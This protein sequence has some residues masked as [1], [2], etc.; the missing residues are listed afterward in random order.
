MARIDEGS[1]SNL[2]IHVLGTLRASTFYTQLVDKHP[3]IAIL[4]YMWDWKCYS[5]LDT[6]TTLFLEY[7]LP[8]DQ[9]QKI[10]SVA[11]L[12]TA[13]TALEKII[14]VLFGWRGLFAPV[15]EIMRPMEGVYDQVCC[16]DFWLHRI[17]NMLA[18]CSKS[19]CDARNYGA[20]VIP[21]Q[22]L[23]IIKDII[24]KTAELSYNHASNLQ[25]TAERQNRLKYAD[26]MVFGDIKPPKHEGERKSTTNPSITVTAGS[27]T[28][29]ANK[30]ATGTTD[31]K[32]ENR[33]AP[34]TRDFSAFATAGVTV[35]TYT[36][37]PKFL[38]C[39]VD[40]MAHY[41]IDFD[42]GSQAKACT[43]KHEAT[44]G[45]RSTARLHFK[46]ILTAYPQRYNLA[47]AKYQA[48]F[49]F[50]NKPSVAVRLMAALDA[51]KVNFK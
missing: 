24:Q 10:S 6:K 28:P 49:W 48:C 12:F 37:R 20:T 7:F 51:D 50:F 5:C 3:D 38:I 29:A 40:L 2:F 22:N 46:D 42:D 31:R 19:T 45:S 34:A 47:S 9:Y 36:E 41:K 27:S 44:Q 1:Q 13:L 14:L 11:L 23:A 33:I 4:L 25:F 18:S 15:L 21:G 35:P 8:G 32:T 26:P 16:A 39:I 30:K 43:K 17:Y